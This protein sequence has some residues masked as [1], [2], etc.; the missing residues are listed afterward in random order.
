MDNE[1]E[2]A[3]L[4]RDFNMEAVKASTCLATLVY[5]NIDIMSKLL[6]FWFSISFFHPGSNPRMCE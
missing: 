5:L 4:K 2:Y 3:A 1:G 6:T